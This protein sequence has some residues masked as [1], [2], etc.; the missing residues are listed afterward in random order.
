VPA[1]ALSVKLVAE[2]VFS[3]FVGAGAIHTL[4]VREDSHGQFNIQGPADSYDYQV[5]LKRGGP[6]TFR[7]LATATELIRSMGVSRIRVHPDELTPKFRSTG[8]SR[9]ARQMSG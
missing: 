7:N 5:R 3:E 4:Y 6:R 2:S 1:K 8:M 9:R